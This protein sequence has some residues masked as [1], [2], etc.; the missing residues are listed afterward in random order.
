MQDAPDCARLRHPPTVL[1]SES[2]RLVRPIL[3]DALSR[4]QMDH[5]R[6]ADMITAMRSSVWTSIAVFAALNLSVIGSSVLTIDCNFTYE[7]VR[8]Y[9]G[10]S[11]PVG[12]DVS[13][14]EDEWV[15]SV[16]RPICR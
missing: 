11:V 8:V 4:H 9:Y 14:V 5:V 3:L 12:S 1:A 15:E 6:Q 13:P 10:A 7:G 16:C 2:N